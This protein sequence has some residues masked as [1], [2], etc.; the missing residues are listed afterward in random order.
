MVVWNGATN[1]RE[2][3]IQGEARRASLGRPDGTAI[4]LVKCHALML[5]VLGRDKA[6]A[7]NVGSPYHGPAMRGS[8]PVERE[9]AATVVTALVC[10][11]S[12]RRYP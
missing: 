8:A 7:T 4:L 2:R 1:L 9:R 6:A 11:K 3:G 5:D 10:R 12:A